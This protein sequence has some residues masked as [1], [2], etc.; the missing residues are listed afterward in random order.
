M[1]AS[2]GGIRTYVKVM[3][4]I[5]MHDSAERCTTM[6]L[7]RRSF[8]HIYAAVKPDLADDRLKDEQ[9]GVAEGEDRRGCVF[10]PRANFL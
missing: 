6:T 5:A 3:R 1:L 4:A 2:I 10:E 7:R 9:N 8:H